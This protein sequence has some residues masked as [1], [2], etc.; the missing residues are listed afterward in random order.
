MTSAR[1]LS[2]FAI[3]IAYAALPAVPAK[4]QSVPCTYFDG[5]FCETAHG[6]PHPSWYVPRTSDNHGLPYPSAPWPYGQGNG[7]PQFRPYGNYPPDGYGM[8]EPYPNGYG[9]CH[10]ESPFGCGQGGMGY[11]G[12]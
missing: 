2:A 6:I 9:A 1:A 4:A 8:R 7:G 10:V 3:A 12:Y 11:G 5:S